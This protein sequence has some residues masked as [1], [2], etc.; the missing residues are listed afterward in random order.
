MLGKLFLIFFTL[1]S[2]AIFNNIVFAKGIIGN[3]FDSS[4]SILFLVG[5]SVILYVLIMFILE[6]A[7]SLDNN[8][9]KLLEGIMIGW[10]IAL[11][12]QLR[13]SRY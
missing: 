9:I 3:I 13:K 4:S 10:T 5:I 8:F 7:L 2:F 11:F 12:S 6:T 1:L